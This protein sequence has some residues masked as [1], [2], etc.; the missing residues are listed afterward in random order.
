[1]TPAVLPT[2]CAVRCSEP[3]APSFLVPGSIPSCHL[4]LPLRH[5][6][7]H[8]SAQLPPAA[9]GHPA[10]PTCPGGPATPCPPQTAPAASGLPDEW[11]Q[12][13]TQVP[14]PPPYAHPRAL[15][16][17]GG[18]SQRSGPRDQARSPSAPTARPPLPA[19]PALPTSCRSPV[20]ISSGQGWLFK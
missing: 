19:R 6:H 3:L 8:L 18:S 13:L 20:S 5:F 1:M 7:G 11:P 2:G 9:M 15:S 17:P 16:T 4:S 12:Q 10:R 14:S